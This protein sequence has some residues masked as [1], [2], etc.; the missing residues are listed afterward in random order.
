MHRK[1][2]ATA[3][4]RKEEQTERHSK[5]T[6]VQ[7]INFEDGDYVLVRCPQPQKVCKALTDPVD[8]RKNRHG[9]F[10]KQTASTD[11]LKKEDVAEILQKNSRRLNY[12]K[13]YA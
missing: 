6:N 9:S 12:L 7:S 10:E 1:I 2:T 3:S 11:A 13:L 4:A 5:C 8:K